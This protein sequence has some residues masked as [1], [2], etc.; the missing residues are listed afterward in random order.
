M[1]EELIKNYFTQI[2]KSS[3]HG[4]ESNQERA[5]MRYRGAM[6]GVV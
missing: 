6:A 4:P 2:G 3:Y 5:A 1:T